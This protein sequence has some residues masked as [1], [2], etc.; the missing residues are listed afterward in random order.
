MKDGNW[1]KDSAQW[2]SVCRRGLPV[3][4]EECQLTAERLTLKLCPQERFHEALV[5]TEA[6][7]LIPLLWVV[8]RI[9]LEG[10]AQ[11]EP[12]LRSPQSSWE[13]TAAE[14]K[15]EE[16][17]EQV[18]LFCAFRFK[19]SWHIM[20]TLLRASPIMEKISPSASVFFQTLTN[21]IPHISGEGS[22]WHCLPVPAVCTT[23]PAK[24]HALLQK[25]EKNLLLWPQDC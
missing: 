2:V 14:I 10:K 18:F 19:F 25:Q 23:H 22:Y 7:F 1:S 3:C 15:K 17:E 8:T 6:F 16:D 5:N 11:R 21:W 20:E 13:I 24:S 9:P 4:P 12:G